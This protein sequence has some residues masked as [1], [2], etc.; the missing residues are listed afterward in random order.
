MIDFEI[1]PA[2]KMIKDFAHG[3]ARDTFRPIA[4]KYD[5]EEHTTAEE[6]AF[7]GPILAQRSADR[8]KKPT[9]DTDK[10][11][12]PRAETEDRVGAT[13]TA[14]VG[15]EEFCWG[16]SGLL[17]AIPGNGLGNAAIAAVATPE[18]DERF[19]GRFAAMAIT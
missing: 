14:V 12:E 7:M 15:S 4:R 19:G 17:L 11:K 13:I 3:V 18:Q 2:L 1:P 10:P 16:D 8:R 6:I 9:K 5:E